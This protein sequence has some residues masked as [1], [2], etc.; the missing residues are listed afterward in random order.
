MGLKPVELIIKR[1]V[2]FGLGN[3]LSQVKR[4]DAR[5]GASTG[6]ETFKEV[7]KRV[8]RMAYFLGI[9]GW[10]RRRQG[11]GTTL[12]H[13]P[14]SWLGLMCDACVHREIRPLMCGDQDELVLEVLYRAF[15]RGPRTVYSS[16][17]VKWNVGAVYEA[18]RACQRTHVADAMQLACHQGVIGKPAAGVIMR[19]RLV[20]LGHPPE[21]AQ[22]LLTRGA[23]DLFS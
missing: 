2:V 7:S 6:R 17:E 1:Y 5:T 22:E 21:F 16:G 4:L 9:A 11:I 12:E 18:L 3:L 13:L 20:A 19:K 23:R 14:Q 15:L 8:H 10:E